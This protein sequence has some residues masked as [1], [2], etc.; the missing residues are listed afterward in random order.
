MPE[1][2][3]PLSLSYWKEAAARLKD[4][5]T[6]AVCSVLMALSIAIASVFIPLPNGLRVYFTFA[7]KAICAM[8][9]GPVAALVFGC[10][11]D[12]LGFLI[13]PTGAFFIGYTISSMFGMFLYALGL[14]RQ[15]IT[16]VRVAL[17][18]LAVNLLCNVGL[19]ALWNSILF[20]KAYLFYFWSS[21]TKNLLL[22]PVETALILLV[23]RLLRSTMEK[24]KLIPKQ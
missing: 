8:I 6:L 5:R 11:E 2:R 1:S 18:K 7:A 10:A 12:L 13:H 9:C 19:G 24:Q 17:T 15:R 22:W 21:L 20:G 4:V 3:S 14:Y 16:V 23:F